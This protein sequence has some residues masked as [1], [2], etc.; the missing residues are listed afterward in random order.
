MTAHST[1][2]GPSS[3]AENVQRVVS[4]KGV[5]AWLVESHAVP[6]VALEFAVAGGS[7]QDPVGKDGLASLMG[8]LLDEGAGDLDS[9][10]FHREVEDLAVHVGFGA[11]RD[12]ISGHFQTLTRNL[13][14]AFALLASALNEPRFDA[15]DVAR[16]RGQIAASLR[17]DANDPDAMAAKAFRENAFPGHVYGRTTRGELET[18]EGLERADCRTLHARLFARKTLKIAVVG[19]IDAATLAQKLDLVFGNWPLEPQLEAVPDIAVANVG[20]RKIVELDVPQS[21]FRFGR[22]GIAR[23]DPDYFTAVVVNHILGGGA[24]TSRFF[25]EVREKRGLA[26]S[27]NSS[28][29]DF[30][31][32]PALFGGAATKNER[33][34]ET[35]QVVEEQCR[36]LGSEGPTKDELDKAK[37]YLTGSYALRFDTSTKIA[38]QLVR[39]QLDGE[40]PSFLDERNAKIE[41]VTLESACAVGQRLL[42]DGKLLVSV[43]GKPEGIA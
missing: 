21:S 5:E 1:L 14:K 30:Q 16:V 23:R 3:R 19:A 26:Y 37:K 20:L 7:A 17:R 8:G 36:L 24:F 2:P 11:D 28:L 18:L 43:V 32:C 9:R 22:G 39:L 38:S 34:G 31:H 15:E 4:P 27:V 12:Q 40:E 29:H 25:N 35:L 41:A 33:A 13:D 10:A 42:G 6:L